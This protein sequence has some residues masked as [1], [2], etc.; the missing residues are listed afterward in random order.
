M[1]AERHYCDLED[2]DYTAKNGCKSHSDAPIWYSLCPLCFGRGC[3]H[4][5]QGGMV[6]EH[7]CIHHSIDSNP[8]I[9]Y[10]ADAVFMF[11]EHKILPH[12]GGWSDQKNRFVECFKIYK[13]AKNFY[14]EKMNPT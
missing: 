9:Q 13:R 10:W 7:R 14:S 8:K 12:G 4:C 11:E 3:S 1:G 6:A 5:E 2:E